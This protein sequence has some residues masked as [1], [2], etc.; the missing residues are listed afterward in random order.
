MMKNPKKMKMRSEIWN[1]ENIFF[2]SSD[3]LTFLELEADIFLC[4]VANKWLLINKNYNLKIKCD[5][6]L[7]INLWLQ[8]DI[9]KWI[10]FKH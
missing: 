7:K 3:N 6:I 10:Y 4:S 9:Y 8:S 1:N 2:R 5:E